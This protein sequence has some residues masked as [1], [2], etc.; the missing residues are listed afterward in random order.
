MERAERVRSHG[1]VNISTNNNFD[2][3]CYVAQV[4]EMCYSI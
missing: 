3:Q 1:T 4:P 2:I